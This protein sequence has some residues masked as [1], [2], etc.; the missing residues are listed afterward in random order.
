MDYCNFDDFFGSYLL[1]FL[2][3]IIA[4]EVIYLRF[5]IWISILHVFEFKKEVLMTL[6]REMSSS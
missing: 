6:N 3:E 1:S 5:R 2:I 4:V